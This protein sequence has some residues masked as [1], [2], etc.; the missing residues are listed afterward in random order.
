MSDYLNKTIRYSKFRLDFRNS[1]SFGAFIS[2]SKKRGFKLIFLR[3]KPYRF[4]SIEELIKKERY[5]LSMFKEVWLLRQAEKSGITPKSANIQ[6]FKKNGYYYIGILMEKINGKTLCQK[7]LDPEEL[8]CTKNGVYFSNRRF[9]EN[10]YVLCRRYI[11]KKLK[12]FNVY[13]NDVHN[14]NVFISKNKV[15]V[16]DFSPH[17]RICYSETINSNLFKKEFLKFKKS[18]K[19]LIK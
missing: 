15:K 5:L 1:G 10:Q 2:I 8:Y 4:L 6:L 17:N 14:G 3:E 13:Y 18:L 9:N 11:K 12:D 16:V 19:I 7:G